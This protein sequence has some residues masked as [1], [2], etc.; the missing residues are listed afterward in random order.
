MKMT[1]VEKL[2]ANYLN[3]TAA[4]SWKA[5]ALPS[6]PSQV[7][8]KLIVK[9]YIAAGRAGVSLHTMVVLQAFQAD[10][11]KDLDCGEG[12]SPDAVLE[13]STDLAFRATKQ[14]ARSIGRSLAAMVATKRHFWLN[15]LW[16]KEKDRAF[17]LDDAYWAFWALLLGQWSRSSKRKR[18]SQW[19]LSYISFDA[20]LRPPLLTLFPHSLLV[21]LIKF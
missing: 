21:L 16:L 3:P 13:L 17:L 15:L 5:P 20:V 6:K 11:L 1:R 4:S 2:L 12:L 8:S 9:A 19:H 18:L 14:S 10:L 7:T